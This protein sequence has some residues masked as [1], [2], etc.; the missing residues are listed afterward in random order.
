MPLFGNF[1]SSISDWFGG[2][3]MSGVDGGID[4]G[5]HDAYETLILPNGATIEEKMSGAEQSVDASYGAP[6]AGSAGGS[7]A[8]GG[9]A[10]TGGGAAAASGGMDPSSVTAAYG[11]YSE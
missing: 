2:G 8:S 4:F 9:G 11:H 3:G 5:G 10:G 1:G 7:V 6:T